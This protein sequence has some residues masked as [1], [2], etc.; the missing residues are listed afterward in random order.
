MDFS[1]FSDKDFEVKKW[2]NEALKAQ[3]DSK[4]PLDVSNKSLQYTI[5]TVIAGS[6]Q[7]ASNEITAVHSGTNWVGVA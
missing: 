4:T 2:V 5:I 7:Y 1:K 6:S 3:K